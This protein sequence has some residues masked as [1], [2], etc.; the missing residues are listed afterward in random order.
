MRILHLGKFY[1]P[2]PGGI[3]NFLRDLARAQVR[4]GHE[5]HVLCHAH[6]GTK[7]LERETVDKVIVTR[8]P[9]AL[10]LAYAPLAPSYPL[11]LRK[12]LTSF[13]PDIVHVHM[14]N[15][16]PFWVLGWFRPTFGLVVHWHADVIPSPNDLGLRLFRPVYSLPE[17]MLLSRA[18]AVVATSSPYADTSPVLGR[19]REKV[20][21]IPLGLD[22]S[23]FHVPDR[24]KAEDGPPLVLSIGRCTPYKG[25]D[26]LIRAW[27][28][29]PRGRLI[30]VGSGPLLDELR[31]LTLRL[32]LADRI[33][34]PGSLPESDLHNLL[35]SCDLFCLPSVERT[36]A[37][38]LVL[39]EA[40]R[41]GKPLITTEVPGS[42][43]SEVNIHGRT[44]LRVPP[45]DPEALAKAVNTL[46]DDPA[47]RSEL[48]RRATSRLAEKFDIV[49][50]AERLDNLYRHILKTMNSR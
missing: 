17:T 30:I 7:N 43:M 2:A 16:S 27:V 15:V 41:Y 36:E 9:V 46:L 3:E 18:G 4:S 12:I 42:G 13:R 22:M 45:R 28:S 24:P 34:L 33:D 20:E 19:F 44:G 48:G 26:Q 40:M 37:F 14:P 5:V 49:H 11:H 47:R 23:R 31:D 10:S 29:V 38:G 35:D 1:P 6:Q 8:V 39:L 50:V 32:G 21:I 25:L